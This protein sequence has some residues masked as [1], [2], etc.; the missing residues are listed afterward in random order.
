MLV[1]CQ[2]MVPMTGTIGHDLG[3]GQSPHAVEK[4]VRLIKNH[5]VVGTEQG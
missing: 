3:H 5:A 2:A 4:D 1:L